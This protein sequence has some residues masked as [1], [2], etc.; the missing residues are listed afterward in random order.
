MHIK[1]TVLNTV[2]TLA[3]FSSVS[4]FSLAIEIEPTTASVTITDVTPGGEVAVMWASRLF[5]VVPQTS[6]DTF[7]AVDDDRDGEIVLD[8]LD[9][10]ILAGALWSVVDVASGSFAAYRLGSSSVPATD[11]TQGAHSIGGTVEPSKVVSAPGGRVF[12]LLVRPGVGA[13]YS[14]VYDGTENDRDGVQ[15]HGVTTNTGALDPGGRA[16]EAPRSTMPGDIIV[17]LD[18]RAMIVTITTVS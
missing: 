4:V 11:I 7:I 14:E 16:P 12:L 6:R 18:S 5:D 15:N 3:L 10:E 17:G 9:K 2:L 13:W 1:S 8:D